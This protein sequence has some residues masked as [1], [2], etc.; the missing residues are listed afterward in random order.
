MARVARFEPPDLPAAGG[1]ITAVGRSATAPDEVTIKV[2][3]RSAGRLDER[4]A[5][6]LRI[7]PGVE[8]SG[9]LRDLV[10]HAMMLAKARQWAIRA[11][12][13]RAMT[14]SMLVTKLRIRGLESAQA[15]RI[16]EEMAEKGMIDERR[17]A[18]GVV[19]S[20]IARRGKGK[21]M[22]VNRL[23]AK[24][25]DARMAGEVVERVT[26]DEGYDPRAA[27]LDL[28][29]RKA[30]SMQRLDRE[31]RQRRLYGV[32]ARRGFDAELCRD[33]IRQVLGRDED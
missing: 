5:A 8:W 1:V 31:A 9:E 18:Q 21:R 13:D 30:R 4:T 28:A 16:A 29:R 32:L 15:L 20:D 26:E 6:R 19:L 25:I 10:A 12:S 27:A 22:M 23:R 7:A 11:V 24:G 17:F 14:R 2:G 3:K 33:V